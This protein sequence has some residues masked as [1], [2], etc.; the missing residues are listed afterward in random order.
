MK[1]RIFAQF[2]STSPTKCSLIIMEKTANYE[3]E[4]WLILYQKTRKE[5]F[6][7]SHFPPRINMQLSSDIA[8]K[9]FL[10]SFKNFT[11]SLTLLLFSLAIYLLKKHLSC[12]TSHILNLSALP[13]NTSIF[14][15]SLYSIPCTM[16]SEKNS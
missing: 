5:C 13:I 11:S 10:Q 7:F 6:Y 1:N 15:C 2:Q 12:R 14:G 3:G 9:M 16:Q 4:G 8:N